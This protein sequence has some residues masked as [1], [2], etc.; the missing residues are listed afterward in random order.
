MTRLYNTIKVH[1][2]HPQ[3]K[4]RIENIVGRCDAC[5]CYKVQGPGYGE[6]PPCEANIA[7][8]DEVVVDCI[9]PWKIE[10]NG[11]MIECNALTCVDPVTCFPEASHINSRTSSH[12]SMKFENEWIS[13]YP[14]PLRCIHDAGGEFTAEAFQIVLQRNEIKD[15][16]TTVKNP[17]SNAICERMHQTVANTLRIL[18]NVHRPQ[19]IN[20][21]ND[22]IDTCLATAMHAVRS[23]VHRS[24]TISPGTFVFRR[25]MFLDVPLIADLA[26]IQQH[27]QVLINERLLHSNMKHRYFD[28]EVGQRVLMFPIKKHRKMQGKAFGPFAII[29]THVNGNV[30]IQ[31]GPHIT[32]RANIRR[33]KPYCS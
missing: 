25:D 29:Q 22:N 2:W 10:V 4:N 12:T 23:T 17:Q 14:R 21:A 1:F 6:L 30:T 31:R 28:Y 32:E 3:L 13:R 24:L 15:V 16:P 19:N 8:W 7:P 18:T 27:R 11:Q 26:S 20:E 9:S 33:I 5:Q